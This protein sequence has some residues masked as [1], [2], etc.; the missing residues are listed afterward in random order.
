MKRFRK[1]MGYFIFLIPSV[2]LFTFC[3]IYPFLSGIQLAFTDWDGISRT[4]N[5]VGL[6]NF[7]RMLGDKNVL[8]P[9][10]TTVIYGVGVTAAN[11]ILALFLAVTLSKKLKGK[12]FF[13]TSFF[14]PLAISAVLASFVWKYIDSNM[15]SAI[16]GRSLLG[17]RETVLLGIIIIS[18]WNNLGS[19]VMIYMAGIAGISRDYEEAAM[20][21]G[22]NTWQR[23]CNVTIPML[24]PSFTICITLT[25]TSS[26]R[27]FGTVLAATGGGPAGSSQTVAILI[28]D[29]M[30]KYSRAGYAQAISLVFM[31]FLVIIGLALTKFFRS[32]E[33]EA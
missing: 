18:L 30:F 25:L 29:Y 2:I 19:N 4:Y 28:Y 23:F 14:I 10:K 26:L 5:F 32:K 6:D 9:I 22:A 12:A 27:E 3:V 21:D 8:Q 1:E 20:I 15:L 7:V 13:K 16:L 24:M 33:V 11:N 17:R 31:V